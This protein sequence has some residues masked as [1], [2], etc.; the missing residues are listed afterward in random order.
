MHGTFE[1]VQIVEML[2]KKIPPHTLLH[3][4][5]GIHRYNK[6]YYGDGYLV[7]PKFTKNSVEDYLMWMKLSDEELEKRGERRFGIHDY[8]YDSGDEAIVTVSFEVFGNSPN[9][10]E[11]PIEFYLSNMGWD[12]ILEDNLDNGLRD[13][14]EKLSAGLTPSKYEDTAYAK[15]LTLW[16]YT[17]EQTSNHYETD[18]NDYISYIGVL[19]Q[20]KLQEWATQL[21]NKEVQSG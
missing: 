8:V 1:H 19:D 13:E 7:L 10:Y 2:I 11:T 14:I 3:R 4:E 6:D 18:Y 5:H 20:S 9:H 15:V 21:S 17:M 16:E 12:E